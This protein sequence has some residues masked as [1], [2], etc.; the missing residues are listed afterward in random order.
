MIEGQ[1]VL[2]TMA[3]SIATSSTKSLRGVLF[4]TH[5]KPT[6]AGNTITHEQTM[7][8]IEFEFQ[9]IWAVVQD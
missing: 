7:L 4:I 8:N 1:V 2:A 6:R 5:T 3:E 9:S